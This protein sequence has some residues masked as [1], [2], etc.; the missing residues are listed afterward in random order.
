MSSQPWSSWNV[1]CSCQPKKLSPIQST[2]KNLNSYT[3]YIVNNNTI[4]IHTQRI[5]IS[6]VFTSTT[7]GWLYGALL[8]PLMAPHAYTISMVNTQGCMDYFVHSHHITCFHITIGFE[9]TLMIS[10]SY[11]PHQNQE[12]SPLQT[13]IFLNAWLAHFLLEYIVTINVWCDVYIT[14]WMLG[15]PMTL[16]VDHDCGPSLYLVN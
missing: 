4:I 11:T 15:W 2:I 8:N 14:S 13:T 9:P 6:I 16:I 5:H 1:P 3:S 12:Q 7:I 10:I